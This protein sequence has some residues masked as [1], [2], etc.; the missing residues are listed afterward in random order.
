[1]Y[2]SQYRFL[3]YPEKG[4]NS[5]VGI[6][7]TKSFGY[8]SWNDYFGCQLRWISSKSFSFLLVLGHLQGARKGL[9]KFSS[10]ALCSWKIRFLN[11]ICRIIHNSFSIRVNHVRVTTKVTIFE[12]ARSVYYWVFRILHKYWFCI[13]ILHIMIKITKNCFQ[14]W[15]QINN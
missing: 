4:G 7:G 15:F 5:K 13:C 14:L 2:N 11:L 9:N 3:K 12:M 8:Y 1:M 6:L 10:N